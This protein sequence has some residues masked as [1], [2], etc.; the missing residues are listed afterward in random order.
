MAGPKRDILVVKSPKR[1]T[2]DIAVSGGG[3]RGEPDSYAQ[4]INPVGKPGG[5]QFSSTTEIEVFAGA[6]GSGEFC[7][8][9]GES[10]T[11]QFTNPSYDSLSDKIVFLINHG[12]G[13]VSSIEYFYSNNRWQWTINFSALTN[14]SV[15]NATFQDDMTGDNKKVGEI[16]NIVAGGC[17]QVITYF[18][19]VEIRGNGC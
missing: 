3:D 10:T 2:Y 13:N 4:C 6:V 1:F 12:M 15:P 14:M 5:L 16:A 9:G 11:V 18:S 19:S 8:T 7:G 17:E